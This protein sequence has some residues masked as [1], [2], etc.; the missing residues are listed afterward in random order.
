MLE[1]CDDSAEF[2][3]LCCFSCFAQMLGE[4]TKTF[5]VS[6]PSGQ[7][8]FDG[9]S[10]VESFRFAFERSESCLLFAVEALEGFELCQENESFFAKLAFS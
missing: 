1:F 6:V 5:D 8:A 2:V 9:L 10:A 3:G 4:K 7:N